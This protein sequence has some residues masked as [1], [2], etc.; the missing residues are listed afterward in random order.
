MKKEKQ[1]NTLLLVGEVGDEMLDKTIKF[2][3]SLKNP[4]DPVE[5]V[6]STEG[7]YVHSG[8]GIF[9]TL[10]NIPNHKTIHC[11]GACMSAGTIILGAGD[12]RTST[13]N[14][15]FMVH[16]GTEY[17]DSEDTSRHN[18]KIKELLKTI[19]CEYTGITKRTINNWFTREKYFTAEQALKL[20]FIDEIRRQS[21]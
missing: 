6:L 7:G 15:Q 11:V 1:Q 16:Y 2:A 3:E 9:D 21:V 18:K 5:I 13:I 17:N 10:V 20:G 12:Y 19:L 8:L 4:L 14:T